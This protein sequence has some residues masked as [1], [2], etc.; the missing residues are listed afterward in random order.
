MTNEE[1]IKVL[2]EQLQYS[3]DVIPAR[4]KEAYE[5]ARSAL[6]QTTW[7]PVSE[8]LPEDPNK[9][10]LIQCNGKYK[11]ITFDEAVQMATYEKQEGWI[12]DGYEEAE[13]VEVVAWM[14]LPEPYK[15]QT[16]TL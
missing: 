14:P 15:M 3:D 2:T 12:L 1:A 11:N 16:E 4:I 9:F 6:E 5:V 7:I 10:V 13:E 8:R